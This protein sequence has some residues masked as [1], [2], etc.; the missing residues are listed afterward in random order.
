MKKSVINLTQSGRTAWNAKGERKYTEAGCQNVAE[1]GHRIYCKVV[2]AGS[3]SEDDG[4]IRNG[5][6]E[7]VHYKEITLA[8]GNKVI[9]KADGEAWE[10][11]CKSGDA[12][13]G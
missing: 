7:K 13:F 4:Q 10:Y 8:E 3:I 9:G 12:G 6:I 2:G 5:V 11:P 1:W